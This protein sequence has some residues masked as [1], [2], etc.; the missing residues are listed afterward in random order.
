MIWGLHVKHHPSVLGTPSVRSKATGVGQQAVS[1]CSWELC[2]CRHI[3][4]RAA[5]RPCSDRMDA[6]RM[7]ARRGGLS[8]EV[9]GPGTGRRVSA[10]G[11]TN[12]NPLVSCEFLLALGF[13][14]RAGGKCLTR[15]PSPSSLLHCQAPGP[16]QQRVRT[17]SHEQ[18]SNDLPCY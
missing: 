15:A 4:G 9:R 6:L 7:A 16:G 11:N 2:R 13:V 1:M 8:G 17:E 14:H 10:S 12:P 5:P 3:Q 18:F